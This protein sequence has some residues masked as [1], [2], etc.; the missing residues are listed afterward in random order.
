MMAGFDHLSSTT[1]P[2]A[3]ST[4]RPS[5]AQATDV[6]AEPGNGR[7][8]VLVADDEPNLRLLVN[9]TIESDEF[10]I[11]EAEDGDQAWQLIQARRPALVLLDVQMPGLTGLELARAIKTEPAL[12]GTRV[13]LLTSKAQEADIQAGLATGA[14]LYLTK[15]FS[16]VQ[17]LEVV[18]HA[19]SE[20]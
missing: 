13:V 2:H 12:A 9:A 20:A 5:G 7:K 11:L 8:A 16:P 17:L 10:E 19:L 4:G 3:S 18:D 15:P 14:D 6:C 1:R